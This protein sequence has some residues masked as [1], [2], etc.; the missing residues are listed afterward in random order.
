LRVTRSGCSV[1]AFYKTPPLEIG[2]IRIGPKGVGVSVTVGRSTIEF[3]AAR[4]SSGLLSSG[5]TESGHRLDISRALDR[6]PVEVPS[7]P[8]A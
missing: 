7:Q 5:A 6:V 1:T 4:H 2:S 3:G 8:K